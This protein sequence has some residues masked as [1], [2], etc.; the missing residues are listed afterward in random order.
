MKNVIVFL[1]QEPRE[2][3]PWMEPELLI[4]TDIQYAELEKLVVNQ[5]STGYF[6]RPGFPSYDYIMED[7]LGTAKPLNVDKLNPIQLD[8]M[9][10]LY[11]T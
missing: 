4:I 8:G 7:V 6:H 11:F 1:V 3:W 5:K 2:D 9:F 10:M